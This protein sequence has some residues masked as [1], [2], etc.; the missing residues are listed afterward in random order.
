MS[1]VQDIVFLR[2]ICY[3]SRWVRL[4]YLGPALL[5]NGRCHMSSDISRYENSTGRRNTTCR[6]W[7]ETG[8]VEKRTWD[9]CAWRMPLLQQKHELH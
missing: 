3:K 2:R 1:S 6:L 9:G 4:H 7:L 8:G 5:R